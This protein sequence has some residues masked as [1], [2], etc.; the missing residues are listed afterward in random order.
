VAQ[1]QDLISNVY[2]VVAGSAMELK[3]CVK[4]TKSNG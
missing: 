3:S 4:N 2:D 1:F